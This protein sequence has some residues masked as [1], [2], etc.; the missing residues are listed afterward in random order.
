MFAF[1]AAVTAGVLAMSG[2]PASGAHG[3]QHK[4]AEASA[5]ESQAP[6]R[7]GVRTVT[8]APSA[9]MDT[10]EPMRHHATEHNTPAAD[11]PGY[12]TELLTGRILFYNSVNGSGAI[13][14]SI[15]PTST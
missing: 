4:P 15:V 5:S 1:V 10:A 3:L 7:V 11:E 12:G 14:R 8:F 13:G 9:R 6:D 2:G